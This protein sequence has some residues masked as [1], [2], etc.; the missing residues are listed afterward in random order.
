MHRQNRPAL[1]IVDDR[2]SARELPVGSELM[3]A[4]ALGLAGWWGIVHLVMWIAA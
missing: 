4:L 3:I 2:T 1:A